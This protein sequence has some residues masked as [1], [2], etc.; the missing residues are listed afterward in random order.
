MALT[1]T[2]GGESLG[3]KAAVER[4]VEELP[5][6]DLQLLTSRDL[7]RHYSFNARERNLLFVN[8]EGERFFD[9]GYA[10][11]ID[12][13][14]EGR[15]AAVADLDQD[16]D[17]DLLVRSVARKKLVYLR[18]QAPGLGHFLRV[19]LVGVESNRDAI[20]AEVRLCTDQ[21]VL[22]RVRKAG[23]GFQGQSEATLHFGLGAAESVNELVVHWP[24][25]GEETILDVPTDR[26]IRI[27]EGQGLVSQRRLPGW[28][29]PGKAIPSTMRWQTRTA[30][31]AIWSPRPGQP[32]L[33]SLWASW[34]LPCRDEVPQLNELYGNLEDQMNM[35]AISFEEDVEAAR[36]FRAAAESDYP[37]ALST[38]RDLEPLLKQAFAG[39]E[40]RLPAAIVLDAAGRVRRVFQGTTPNWILERELRRLIEPSSLGGF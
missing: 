4:L 40:L 20:G 22:T 30:D 25:G 13:D 26:L 15:G 3:P 38:A 2:R 21:G 19:D 37:M 27:V 9:A 8:A 39:G 7:F 32:T 6:S 17:L 14:L 11:G 29:P 36:R 31:G 1:P 18:N 23:N 5:P 16:G 10:L 35:I 34:C 28:Q 12:V 24:S 33:V